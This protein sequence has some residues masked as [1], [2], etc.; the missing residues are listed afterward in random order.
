MEN[1]QGKRHVSACVHIS[2]GTNFGS[3]LCGSLETPRAGMALLQF[4]TICT[5]I[6]PCGLHGLTYLGSPSLLFH[7][8]FCSQWR[9][10]AHWK[11]LQDQ[12]GASS[13]RLSTGG[14]LAQHPPMLG[15]Q[16]VRT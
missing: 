16:R 7:H 4:L 5:L 9:N 13:L 12:H 10:V 8:L 1:V 15:Q 2:S 14:A 3:L 6:C 11:A